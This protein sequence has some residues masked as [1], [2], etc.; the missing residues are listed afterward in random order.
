LLDWESNKSI[1]IHSNNYRKKLNTWKLS[2]KAGEETI[3]SVIKLNRITGRIILLSTKSLPNYDT[4]GP[5]MIQYPPTNSE[6]KKWN[7]RVHF[8]ILLV[9]VC[10]IMVKYWNN[11]TRH[12][13]IRSIPKS[14]YGESTGDGHKITAWDLGIVKHNTYF[15]KERYGNVDDS[16]NLVD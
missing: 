16:I 12:F 13:K 8:W 2:C 4:V 9:D 11:W 5:W 15:P 3:K 14:Q 10:S 7:Q 6:F 1:E